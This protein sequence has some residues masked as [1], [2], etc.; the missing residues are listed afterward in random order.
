MKQVGR[1]GWRSRRAGV[2]LL[3]VMVAVSILGM[4]LAA[5]A[6]IESASAKQ[7]L[8][9]YSDARTLHRAHLVLERIRYKL[10][11]AE[12]GTVV[13]QDSG[14]H[15]GRTILYRNPNLAAGVLSKFTFHDGALYYHENKD[16]AAARPLINMVNDVVFKSDD[17]PGDNPST[18]G[19][20]VKTLQRYSWRLGR[21][22]TLSTEVTLRN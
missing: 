15:I 4:T 7:T 6:F 3:E 19:I 12:V 20:T 21:P 22:Y 10:C 18:V 14:P 1:A 5:V 11:M 17:L 8:V 16:G 9:L 13:V 2:T